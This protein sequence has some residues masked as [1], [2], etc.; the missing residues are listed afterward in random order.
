MNRSKAGRQG[1]ARAARALEKAGLK[2][3]ARNIRSPYGEVDLIALEGE[4]VVFAEV[5]SW[6]SFGMENLQNSV[7]KKKQSRIIETAKDFLANHSE[8][9]EY[10]IRF[11]VVF[12]S[13]QK[14]IHIPSAFEEET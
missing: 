4:T 2:I 7:D 3:I 10:A 6:T 12:I 9:D 1:E 13:S 5:K 8:F 14:V 11:D